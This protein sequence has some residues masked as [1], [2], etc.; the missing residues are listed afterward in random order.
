MTATF[1][2]AEL[3]REKAGSRGLESLVLVVVS[4]V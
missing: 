2:C 4:V 3:G 1:R